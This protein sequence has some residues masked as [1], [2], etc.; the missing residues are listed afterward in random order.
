[1]CLSLSLL[2]PFGGLRKWNLR[3]TS[4]EGSQ[5]PRVFPSSSNSLNDPKVPSTS[6]LFLVFAA[7]RLEIS[8]G[9]YLPITIFER[10]ASPPCWAS[11]RSARGGLTVVGIVTLAFCPLPLP[12]IIILYIIMMKWWWFFFIWFPWSE[13][14]EWARDLII[15]IATENKYRGRPPPSYYFFWAGLIF[16]ELVG[17]VVVFIFLS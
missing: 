7:I 5:P 16:S 14:C 8:G 10:S 12:L 2:W 3:G 13:W 4:H 15:Q 1:M 11:N 17:S 9:M 6:A